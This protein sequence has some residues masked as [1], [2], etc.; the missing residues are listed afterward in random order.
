MSPELDR[1]R[2]FAPRGPA[3]DSAVDED[4]PRVVR[5]LEEYLAALE[6]G[7]RPDRSEFLARH[8]EVAEVL[9][10]CLGAMELVR[11]AAQDFGASSSEP[12]A[13]APEVR[14]LTHLGDFRIV[15]EVGRGGMGIVYEAQQVSLGRRVALKVLPYASA[16]DPRHR[17]RFQVE[18]QAAAH[19]HHAHIVPVFAVGSD[20]GVHYYA[21]QFIDGPSLAT[22]IDELR[23]APERAAR[24]PAE[25]PTKGGARPQGPPST[26]DATPRR[27]AGTSSAPPPDSAPLSALTNRDRAFFH[28]VA[29]LG[30]QAAEALEHAHALGVVH[31][32]VKPANLMLD[33][34]GKL[35]M[36][37]FG[38]ARFQDD[39]GLTRSGDLLGTLR[40]MSPEQAQA[41]RVVVD[42]RTDIYSLGVTLYEL[43]ALRPAFD[44][45]DRQELL[46]QIAQEEPPAPR[47]ID[48]AIPRDL[49]TIVL[50]AMAK[51][52]A[53][54]YASAQELADDLRRFL[55]DQPICA[56][57]PT[58]LEAAVRWSRRHRPLVR[59]AAVTAIMLK[60]CLI[61][62]TLLI[63]QAK[64]QTEAALRRERQQ[65]EWAEARL[66]SA[67]EAADGVTVLAKKFLPRDPRGEGAAWELLQQVLGFQEKLADIGVANP[68]ARWRTAVLYGKIGDI[69]QELGQDGEAE[70]AYGKARA[71]L[72]RL[73]DEFPA[74]PIYR[75]HL[76]NSLNNLGALM[77]KGRRFAEAERAHMRALEIQRALAAAAP[78]DPSIRQEMARSHGA[79]GQVHGATGKVVEMERHLGAAIELQSALVSEF[80]AEPGF[81]LDLAR[82]YNSLSEPLRSICHFDKALE[83]ARK[84]LALLEPLEDEQ[85]DEPAIREQLA[86]S[87]YSLGN[88]LKWVGQDREALQAYARAQPYLDE[89]AEDF[90]SVPRYRR[91]RAA[92]HAMRGSLMIFAGETEKAERSLRLAMAIDP[93][94]DL[95]H[96][97]LAWLL[98]TQPQ[99]KLYDPEQ[100]VELARKA[101]ALAPRTGPLCHSGEFWNTLGVA[102]ARL[103]DWKQARAALDKS[104]ELRNGGD[105][106]DWFF[107]AMALWHEGDKEQAR[108]WYDRSVLWTEQYNPKDPALRQFRKEAGALLGMSD[109]RPVAP[110]PRPRHPGPMAVPDPSP[111]L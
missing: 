11:S 95:A 103:G 17:Q 69:R 72:E 35:W 41:R 50:K 45:R 5:A 58:P 66:D 28:A 111:A 48:P 86:V 73:A 71:L 3:T 44:G 83:L 87:Y 36:T 53:G 108:R 60:L 15:R 90:P 96:N 76:A 77:T 94:N 22:V 29:R 14:P 46:R 33:P 97:N 39:P 89:L 93:A 1:G 25:L 63:W 47:R 80:P 43:L 70:H 79:L 75:H 37:D 104:M 84:A 100:A 64:R 109:R 27:P 51:E 91:Q 74:S 12:S 62:S 49:E 8:A 23:R 18:A 30:L 24:R 4:D 82:T 78:A 19:L 101:I 81:K 88:A 107:L 16:L 61:V 6:R 106:N 31:R 110:M 68:S 7:R 85:P 92:V 38:L 65:R 10:D 40:Y 105:A 56:R 99:S 52:V 42:H 54:R 59:A 20:R 34:D 57:R 26:I 67:L 9:A 102:Y 21:M 2:G 13:D 55:D 98:V 32:D